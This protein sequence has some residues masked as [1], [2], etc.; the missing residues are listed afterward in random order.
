MLHLFILQV[1][2]TKIR[3]YPNCSSLQVDVTDSSRLR[4]MTLRWGTSVLAPHAHAR[5]R[6][7]HNACKLI[8]LWPGH[9]GD[10]GEKTIRLISPSCSATIKTIS[11]AVSAAACHT[12]EARAQAGSASRL[13]QAVPHCASLKQVGSLIPM[14]PW[15]HPVNLVFL[16]L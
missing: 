14:L 13:S 1:A 12:T 4:D 8:F 16:S 15:R 10:R 7:Y 9:D 6:F 3:Q 2:V 11:P 5:H